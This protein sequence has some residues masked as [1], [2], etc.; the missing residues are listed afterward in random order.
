MAFQTALPLMRSL[1]GSF[2]GV[3]LGVHDCA[4]DGKIGHE[5]YKRQMG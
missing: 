3:H 2:F 1:K 4:K 5:W